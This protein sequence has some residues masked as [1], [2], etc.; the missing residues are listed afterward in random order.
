M[1]RLR[2]Q[3][4]ALFSR[5]AENRELEEE[6]SFHLEQETKRL[7]QAGVDPG[8]ARRRAHVAFGGYDR[9][10]EEA[11]EARGLVWLENAWRDLRFGAR[12]LMRNPGFTSV[13]ILTLAV[14]IGATTAVFA[15]ANSLLL[16][17]VAGVR[18]AEDLVVVQLSPE[19]GFI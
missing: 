19:R 13:A 17:P 9:V 2:Q 1:S 7:V 15:L 16:R 5:S 10:V 6:L 8:E 14:G 4:G 18:A 3:L 11:G 12:G